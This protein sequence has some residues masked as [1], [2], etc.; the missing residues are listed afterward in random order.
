MDDV[1]AEEGEEGEVDE[2]GLSV[3]NKKVS[4]SYLYCCCFLF[5]FFLS[6]AGLNFLTLYL[7]L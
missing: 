5:G 1:K 7:F 3:S 4:F 6:N 2:N